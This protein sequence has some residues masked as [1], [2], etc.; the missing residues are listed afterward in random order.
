M[1]K[2]ALARLYGKMANIYP[3]L[4]SIA[5]KETD[6]FKTL[7]SGERVEAENKFKPFFSFPNVTKLVFSCN[8]P[9]TPPEDSDAYWRRWIII[10]FPNQ[11]LE[12]DPKTDPDLLQKLTTP[13]E[14]SGVL[15]WA[16]EGLHTLTKQKKFTVSKTMEDTRKQYL[17]LGDPIKAFAEAKLE[18][19]FE[20]DKYLDKPEVYEAYLQFCE[21][22][23]LPYV[24]SIIFSR[25]LPSRISCADGR[26]KQNGETIRVWKNIK[27]KEA[28]DKEE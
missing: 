4:P 24:S 7:V 22:N 21:N 26:V 13:E 18:L 5:L 11:F 9:P 28:M 14:L 2:F 12:E 17:F 27:F 16:L 19:A 10:R 1:H 3:D 6:T 23:N 15:N 8:Q 25:E 20:K